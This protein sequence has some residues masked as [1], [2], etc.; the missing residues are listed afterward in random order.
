MRRI[1]LVSA[2]AIAAAIALWGW[3]A[4]VRAGLVP[5]ASLARSAPRETRL[6]RE[7]RDEARRAG[8]AF[9]VDQRWVPYARISPHLRRA[10]LVAEDD[11]FFG[12]AGLDWRELGASARRNLKAGRVVRG[13]STITQQLAKNLFLGAA[14]TPDRKLVEVALALRLERQLSK[15]RILELYLN[16]IEWGDGIYGAEAAARRYFGVGA[17]DLNPRQ[18]V[19]LAAVIIN[20]R[21]YSVLHPSPRIER[22]ARLIAGRLHRRGELDD[23]QYAVALG[24]APERV[25]LFDWLFG[26]PSADTASV[27]EPAPDSSGVPGDEP[28]A[29]PDSESVAGP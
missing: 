24:R 18:A 16:L 11:K 13:G 3:S 6:M 12:H 4:F 29:P 8:R 17:S 5:I 10:V 21:R 23:A 20:P 9:R 14:R 15:R 7:R 19:L 28:L 25:G 1:I 27:P 2:L 22:R 26:P